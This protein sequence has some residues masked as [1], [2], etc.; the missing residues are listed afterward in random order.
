MSLGESPYFYGDKAVHF[1][2]CAGV[3]LAVA[4]AVEL[5]RRR[6]APREEL[7]PALA[8][9]FI[10]FYFMVFLRECWAKSYDYLVYEGAAIAVLQNK[11]LYASGYLYPPLTAQLLE[12]SYLISEYLAGRF[13]IE[14]DWTFGWDI[15][16]YFYQC[17]QYFATILC[18]YLCY[19]FARRAGLGL[20]VGLALVT[21]LFILN[22]PLL[23]TLRYN[24]VNLFVLDFVLVAIL[25]IGRY[26]WASGAA[27]SVAAHVKL[28]PLILLGP[29]AA[30]KKRAAVLWSA[31]A[32]LAIVFVQTGWGRDWRW[33]RQF[34][35]F[36]PSIPKYGHYRNTCFRNIVYH[37]TECAGRLFGIGARTVDTFTAVVTAAGTLAAVLWFVV[38]FVKRERV[39]ADLAPASPAA[40]PMPDRRTVRLFAH[41]VDALLLALL[42]SPMAWEHHYV[43]ALPV[44]IWAFATRGNDKLWQIGVAAFLILVPP[45]FDFF[46]LSCHRFVGLLLLAI[47]TSPVPLRYNLEGKFGVLGAATKRND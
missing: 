8:F 1:G 40:G 20:K 12:K 22:T 34:V 3:A 4:A 26:P 30:M 37:F 44:I 31:L 32:F 38:R 33:W 9:F 2:L 16:F 25:L 36:L 6:G 13:G 15:V 21:A 41:S 45:T 28:Y 23:R 11:A 18:F 35:A 42:I 27:L 46:I 24:Q 43:F 47:Y 10:S 7:L 14:R 39:L 17:G 29:W 19:K 5:R